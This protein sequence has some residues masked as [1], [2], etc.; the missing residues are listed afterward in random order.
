MA[1]L[2]EMYSRNADF[3]IDFNSKSICVI[4]NMN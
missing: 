1:P 2:L 3:A 4:D